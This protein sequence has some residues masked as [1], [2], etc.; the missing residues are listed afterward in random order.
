VADYAQ[1]VF[2]YQNEPPSDKDIV[3][4]FDDIKIVIDKKSLVY[5]NGMTLEYK[6][7]F[8]FQ[9]FV[10]KNF[11]EKSRCGCGKSVSF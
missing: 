10:F 3:F 5:L 2:E 7:T 9:G 11:N 6:N 1:D 8:L 4:Q